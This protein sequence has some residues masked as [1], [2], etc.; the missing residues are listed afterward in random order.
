MSS[1]SDPSEIDLIALTAGKSKAPKRKTSFRP[2]PKRTPRRSDAASTSADTADNICDGNS[3]YLKD[4]DT[5]GSSMGAGLTA[6]AN[7][8]SDTA[9]P[10]VTV[11][12]TNSKDPCI[13][14]TG[15]KSQELNY[16]TTNIFPTNTM[17]TMPP[18]EDASAIPLPPFQGSN[19]VAAQEPEMKTAAL[20]AEVAAEE[21]PEKSQKA[22]SAIN[23]TSTPEKRKTSKSTRQKSTSTP[24]SARRKKGAALIQARDPAAQSTNGNTQ[25]ALV[26]PTKTKR[27]PETT[28]SG[29]P[30]LKQFC[31]AYR[32]KPRQGAAAPAPPP[33]PPAPEEEIVTPAAPVVRL[34]DG[35]IVLQESSMEVS[36]NKTTHQ[37]A[38]EEEFDVVEEEAQLGGI[39]STY[40]SFRKQNRPLHWSVEETKKFYE[41]LRQ[42][43][44]DFGTMEF[45]FDNPRRNRKSLKQKFRQESNK[46]PKLIEAALNP[47][48]R[49]KIGKR[50]RCERLS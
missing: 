29:Q 39:G 15:G 20:Q 34:V 46:N 8:A 33:P 16:N 37:Q 23:I 45:F 38:I 26:I 13:H 50:N 22:T 35:K 27:E 48:A 19:A 17:D 1:P 40:S 18:L 47:K 21:E 3:Q 42:V 7:A 9:S 12:R 11:R 41:A 31:S 4:D 49:Q 36:G 10:S 6:L 28:L 32:C 43:G 24:R 44:Q 5:Q 2:N 25:A 14:S 30:R